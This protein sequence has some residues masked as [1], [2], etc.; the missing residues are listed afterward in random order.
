MSDL[1]LI[2]LD[3]EDL[4]VVSAHV[5]DAVMKVGEMTFQRPDKR[6]VAVINRFDW[7][8]DAVSKK[9]FKKHYERR[10]SGLRF[11]RVQAVRTMR[12]DPTKTNDVL[13]L[14]A[15]TFEQTEAPAGRITLTFSGGM[16]I[17]LDVE[18]IEAE[19]RDLGAA[20]TTDFRPRHKLNPKT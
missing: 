4:Q 7:E 15:I 3:T 18:C 9:R 20:W 11:E 14:L 8:R 17:E 6:F 1:K 5:Q 2:A 16:A 19:L 13:S 12:I 10:R